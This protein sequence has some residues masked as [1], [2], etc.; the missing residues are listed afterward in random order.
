[1]RSSREPLDFEATVEATLLDL[2]KRFRLKKVLFD[3]FQ[4]HA[5]AQ[6]LHKA[7]LRMVEFPQTPANLTLIGSGLFELIR[8]AGLVTYPDDGIHLPISRAVPKDNARALQI[9]NTH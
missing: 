8:S 2:A 4:M 5:T 6:R 7:G 1:Q 3:P 9:T